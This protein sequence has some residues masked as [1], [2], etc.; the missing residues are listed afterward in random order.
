M[1]L[2][3]RPEELTRSE[4]SRL[5]VQQTLGGAWADAFDR[6]VSTISLSGTTGW[7]GSFFTSGEDAFLQLRSTAFQGWHDRRAKAV[8]SGQDPTEVQ[9]IF[10]DTL[11][12]ITSIVAPK[13]F[14][15][16]RSRTSPLL[17]RYQ[18]QLLELGDADDPNGIIDE[19]ISAFSNPL[20]WIASVTGLGNI[21]GQ[22]DFYAQEAVAVFGSISSG[23]RTFINTGA[24]LLQ[25]VQST[26]EELSGQFDEATSSLLTVGSA[27]SRAAANAFYALGADDTLPASDRIP[28]MALASNFNDAAC[29]LQNGLNSGLLIPNFGDLFGASACSSTGGGSPASIFTTSLLNPFDTMFQP[30]PPPVAVSDEARNAI[31]VLLGDPTLLANDVIVVGGLMAAAGTGVQ[32]RASTNA[33]PVNQFVAPS[34]SGGGGVVGRG[35]GGPEGVTGTFTADG[36]LDDLIPAGSVII[37]G[38]ITANAAGLSISLGTTS[39]GSDLLGLTAV[40]GTPD[41]GVPLQGVNFSEGLFAAD[42]PVFVH[43]PSWGGASA[44]V[45]LWY[46]A[47]ASA[48]LVGTFT[49]DGSMAAALPAGKVIYAGRIFANNSAGVTVSLGSFSGGDDILSATAITG[50]PDPGQPIQGID[51]GQTVFAGN[52]PI[53]VHSD[54]WSGGASVTVALWFL[55]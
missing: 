19:I 7:R 37:G 12:T 15:L 49:A 16:R 17:F 20:R 11:N 45:T 50:A 34:S 40:P 54:L 18:I 29:S 26:A 14:V 32:V 52:Q 21:L 33:A 28:I 23:I 6:G 8:S 44:T 24:S 13:T 53:F 51:F 31:G 46:L 10:T 55:P 4:P 2:T 36:S 9:L 42:Q 39:G 41:P 25:A 3:I 43:S 48:D 47:P 27:Y 30:A 5:A 1:N 35:G 38:K 22:I